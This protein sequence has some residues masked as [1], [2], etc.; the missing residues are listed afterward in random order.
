MLMVLKKRKRCSALLTENKYKLK[1]AFLVDGQNCKYLT[2]DRPLSCPS[3][4]PPVATTG[5]RRS[6]E[7]QRSMEIFLNSLHPRWLPNSDEVRN[8]PIGRWNRLALSFPL[9]ARQMFPNM[10]WKLEKS[11]TKIFQWCLLSSA[12]SQLK[13]LLHTSCS[14]CT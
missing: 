12:S 11:L 3:N 6:R 10:V 1:S 13:L 9:A 5:T 4:I 8:P 2:T 7:T 14:F